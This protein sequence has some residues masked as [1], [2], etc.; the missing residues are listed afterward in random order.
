MG[1][2]RE[3]FSIHLC[4]NDRVKKDNKHI[5]GE[6]TMERKQ[7]TFYRSFLEGIEILP[8]NKEKLQAYETICRYAIF[9]TAPDRNALK[10]SVATLFTFVQPV[11]DTAKHRAELTKKLNE[12]KQ[13]VDI[14][15]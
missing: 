11:L 14:I 7:F 1:K 12:R 10:P 15:V 8:T 4:Y 2:K 9:G 5:K 3:D 13:L 6:K